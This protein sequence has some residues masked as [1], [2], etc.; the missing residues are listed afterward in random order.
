MPPV[1]LLP[2]GGSAGSGGIKD[3][4]FRGMD[5]ELAGKT[6]LVTGA[7]K[8]IGAAVARSLAA[9]GC[10]LHLASR[11]EVDLAAVAESLSATGVSVTIHPVDLAER[12]APAALAE[13][14]GRVDVLVNNAGAVPGGDL[15]SV[16]EDAW[17]E[18]WDLK[19]FGYVN[20]MRSMYRSMRDQGHG[21]IVNVIGTGGERPRF[22]YVAG[23]GGN[24]SLMAI[25]RAMGG[26]SP[27]DNIRVVA[28]NPGAT[29]TERIETV[30]KAWARS[31]GRSEDEW[32]E[33]LGP[34]PFG[35]IGT[36]EEVADLV[37]FL[38]S[39]RASY[40]SGTVVTIDGGSVS[41]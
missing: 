16:D 3:S 19:V 2:S 36:A 6:A 9:E 31:A 23:A 41:R 12:G 34:L 27:D 38:A 33:M 22:D 39:E 40:I 30:A 25:T 7:S 35:R 28:V 8:G 21:V 20:L 13:T 1:V 32:E 14:V 29:K 18:G 17:R 26:R 24:A 5:L 37:T 11:T 15:D 4:T 10:H